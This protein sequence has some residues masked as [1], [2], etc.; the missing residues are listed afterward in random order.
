MNILKLLRRRK[1]KVIKTPQQAERFEVTLSGSGGQG[2]ILAGKILAEAASIF[3]H[4]E[5]V[6]TQS[7][8]PEARG[9]A[10]RAEIIISSSKID[11]P[12]AMKVNILLAMTQEAMDKYGK[13][14]EPDG[15]LIVDEVLVKNVPDEIKNVFKAPF[16]SLASKLLD[17]PIVANI[18]ALSSLAAITGIISRDAL[19]RAVIDRVPEK[20]IVLDRVAVDAGFKAVLDSGFKWEERQ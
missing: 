3:D 14:L 5:A 1:K 2:M 20:V 10:S 18:I 12:K 17:A 8:G 19:I 4:K 6:M 7:Y 11:Y 15:L 13:L 9:G 16:T